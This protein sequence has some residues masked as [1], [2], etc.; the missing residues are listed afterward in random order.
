MGLMNGDQS[1]L[2]KE[3]RRRAVRLE[4]IKG[5]GSNSPLQRQKKSNISRKEDIGGRGD[6]SENLLF[7]SLIKYNIICILRPEQFYHHQL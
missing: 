4:R 2:R 6:A 1:I 7:R 5:A 3:E